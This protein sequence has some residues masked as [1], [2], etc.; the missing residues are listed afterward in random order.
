MSVK[1]DTFGTATVGDDV[2]SAAV[3]DVFDLR[4]KGIIEALDLLRPIYRETAY[5]G[6]FGRK[7]F[8]WEKTNKTEELKA[9]VKKLAVTHGGKAA[10]G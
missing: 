10:K 6:H 1:V 3:Q 2:L 5:H 9:S 8:S 4:P 7:Q